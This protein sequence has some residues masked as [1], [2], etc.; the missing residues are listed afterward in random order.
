MGAQAGRGPFAAGTLG[1][2]GLWK[3]RRAAGLL[4]KFKASCPSPF[5]PACPARRRPGPGIGDGTR[6]RGFRGSRVGGRRREGEAPALLWPLPLEA[7]PRLCS[8]SHLSSPKSPPLSHPLHLPGF[9]SMRR[10]PDVSP[11]R[12]S[13]I[14]PQLRQLK[15]LVVDEAIKEDLKWSRS[16]EDLTGGPAGLTSIEE[17]ILR[18]T[19]YYGYQPWAASYKSKTPRFIC[20]LAPVR[21]P[22]RGPLPQPGECTQPRVQ[23]P[24]CC[25]AHGHSPSFATFRKRPRDGVLPDLGNF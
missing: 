8:P 15:Y 23:P 24:H 6:R 2:V 22:L 1:S 14:S 11:R 3:G 20:P 17:R 7:R 4:G 18:I 10:S 9:S 12:L 21:L 19:G 5:A 13:D 16:V 25:A